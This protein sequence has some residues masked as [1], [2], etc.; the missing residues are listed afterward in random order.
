MVFSKV[1][2]WNNL[3]IVSIKFEIEMKKIT[4]IDFCVEISELQNSL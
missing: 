1:L 2:F 3:E 4:E